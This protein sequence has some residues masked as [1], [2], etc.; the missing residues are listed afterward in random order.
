MTRAI[1]RIAHQN[2]HIGSEKAYQYVVGRSIL[3]LYKPPTILYVGR[4]QEFTF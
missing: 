4:K 1:E 3:S 2:M